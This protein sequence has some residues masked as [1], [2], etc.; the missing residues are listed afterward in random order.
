MTQ[1]QLENKRDLNIR[2]RS[3]IGVF[4]ASCQSNGS[5]ELIQCHN[6]TGFCWCVDKLG[7]ELTGTRQWGKPTCKV[8]S[9]L[10]VAIAVGSYLFVKLKILPSRIL[11]MKKRRI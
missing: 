2:S 4:I 6:A 3:L 10:I 7:N 5:Y 9:K 11:Y 8:S 1:C